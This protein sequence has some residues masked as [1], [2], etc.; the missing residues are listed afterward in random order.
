M[1]T[2]AFDQGRANSYDIRVQQMIPGY[3]VLHQIA[4]VF[5][6]AEVPEQASLLTVGAGT[7]AELLHL[8]TKHPSWQFTATDPAPAMIKLGKEKLASTPLEKQVNW[9]EGPLSTL[10][11]ADPFDAAT[12]ILVLHFLPDNG[13][14]EELLTDIAGR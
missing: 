7:G 3:A 14:K 10:P 5:L 11:P 9:H 4:D 13:A 8:G 1:T 6:S 2:S 12:L